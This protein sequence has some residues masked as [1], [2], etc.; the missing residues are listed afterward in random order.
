M[1]SLVSAYAEEALHE[2]GMEQPAVRVGLIEDQFAIREA[3]RTLLD[4][5]PGY[6][7]NGVFGS[8][9]EALPAIGRNPPDVLLVDIGLPGMS[10]I[11]GIRQVRELFVNLP[12][13]VLTVY[14]DDQR[15]FEAMCAGAFGY[16]LKKTSFPRLLECIDEVRNGG[17]PMSPEVARRVVR[18]FR[19]VR[20]P[21]RA[22]CALTPHEGRLL[23]LLVDGHSYKTAA[24]EL[25]VSAHTVSFH[26]RHIYEKLQVHSKSE[27]VSKAL[28]SGLVE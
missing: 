7:A 24:A 2:C 26:L 23:K 19:D 21:E 14:A 22:S 15:I 8:M 6:R 10:G 9:E 18:L 4:G 12:I 3:L 28:R 13:L 27:A 25:G 20:P 11:E 5:S 17:A 1:P 16:L